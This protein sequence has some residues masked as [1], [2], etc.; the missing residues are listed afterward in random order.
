MKQVQKEMY[1]GKEN[2]WEDQTFR[3][4]LLKQIHT[5]NQVGKRRK[6]MKYQNIKKAEHENK[7]P[8]WQNPAFP[9]VTGFCDALLRK[10]KVMRGRGTDEELVHSGKVRIV[11]QMFNEYL[12]AWSGF[13]VLELSPLQAEARK[14]ILL[15]RR[16][17]AEPE[18]TVQR[19]K[20][21]GEARA[22]KAAAERRASEEQERKQ[23]LEELPAIYEQIVSKCKTADAKVRQAEMNAN[24]FLA[25][26]SKATRFA[27]VEEEIPAVVCNFSAGEVPDPRL[28]QAVRELIGET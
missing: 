15:I 5:Q 16:Q 12:E 21:S 7:M 27:V 22:A 9:R 24:Q 14:R 4:F 8:V 23:A 19:P 2:S 28:M 13:L 26:Y 20:T 11:Q 10:A 25:R 3:E 1:I 6:M 18:G 17:G